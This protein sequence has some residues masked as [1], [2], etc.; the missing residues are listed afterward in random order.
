MFFDQRIFSVF[1]VDFDGFSTFLICRST[2]NTLQKR[3]QKP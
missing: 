1:D 3:K 2:T